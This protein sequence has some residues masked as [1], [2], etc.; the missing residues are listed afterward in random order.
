MNY[1]VISFVYS[2]ITSITINQIH[3]DQ[4]AVIMVY[5]HVSH[6]YFITFGIEPPSFEFGQ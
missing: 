4:V 5:S 3:V 6:N 2:I 1:Q